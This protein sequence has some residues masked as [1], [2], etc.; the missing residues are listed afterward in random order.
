MEFDA[1]AP[2]WDPLG[3]QIPAA[4][5]AGFL[6]DAE[7]AAQI[8]VPAEEKKSDALQFFVIG[9]AMF[10]LGNFVP[11]LVYGFGNTTLNIIA[12]FSSWLLGL[13]FMFIGIAKLNNERIRRQAAERTAKMR[14]AKPRGWVVSMEKS[15]RFKELQ[16]AF[17]AFMHPRGGGALIAEEWWGTWKSGDEETPVWIAELQYQV[18]AGKHT[19]TEYSPIVGVRI[20]SSS[21]VS[22]TL[23]PET[24]GAKFLQLF[25]G[26]YKTGNAEFDTVFSVAAGAQQSSSMLPGVLTPPFIA[27]V[28]QYR[29]KKPLTL[30]RERDLLLVRFVSNLPM[31]PAGMPNQPGTSPDA[32]L[33]A[34][35]RG[36]VEPVVALA[37]QAGL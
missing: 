5:M 28:M 37:R 1:S 29:L 31:L 18:Q 3:A 27:A 20:R 7:R 35:I 6:A 17:P 22:V 26:D 33:D 11:V 30:L 10:V 8:A 23:T 13:P 24:L 2:T 4:Q 36:L 12:G 25:K 32:A 21:P 19:R 14:Y 34:G 9:G 16:A 15:S